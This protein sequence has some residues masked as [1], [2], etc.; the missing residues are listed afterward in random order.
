MLAGAEHLARSIGRAPYL[1]IPCATRPDPATGGPGTNSALHGSLYPAIWQVN[2]A[3]RA[4]GLGTVITTLHLHHAASVAALLGI[5]DGAVQ[6]TMLPVAYTVGTDFKVA[7]RRPVDAV[8]YLDRW[9]TPLPYRDKPVD[10]LTGE[11][12]G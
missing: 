10:R 2:L 5:P 8:S 6:I 12:H 1:V 7:A 4:R 3:L 11:D 9:G